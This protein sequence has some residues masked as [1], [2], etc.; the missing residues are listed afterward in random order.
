[1]VKLI[2]I[3]FMKSRAKE[4]RIHIWLSIH[5]IYIPSYFSNVEIS[6]NYNRELLV[7]VVITMI[8]A[9]PILD[10]VQILSII[11]KTFILL[12]Q[13]FST[14]P[15]GV[16]SLWSSFSPSHHPPSTKRTID[17]RHWDPRIILVLIV[18]PKKFPSIHY[19]HCM[20][21]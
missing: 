21:N 6:P 7:K 14:N 3:P 9:L 10:M 5:P 2:V 16:L 13:L 19:L 15:K 20:R 17:A 4:Y 18:I 11:V 8:R 12:A 1:M